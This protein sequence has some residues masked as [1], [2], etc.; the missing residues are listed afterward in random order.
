MRHPTGEALWDIEKMVVH[1]FK[2]PG[3]SQQ[4]LLFC[5]E[6]PSAM[7]SVLLTH[8]YLFLV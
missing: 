1:E 6:T 5:G 7:S 3:L 4:Y 2:L 8:F